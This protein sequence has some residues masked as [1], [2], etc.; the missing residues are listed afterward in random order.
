[1]YEYFV[2]PHIG[3]TTETYRSIARYKDGVFERYHIVD[4]VWF[5]DSEMFGIFCGEYEADSITEAQASAIV[6]RLEAAA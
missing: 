3:E 6:A 1:M 2:L 4:H 5:E